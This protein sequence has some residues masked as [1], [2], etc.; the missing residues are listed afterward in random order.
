MFAE[1]R[2]E[3]DAAE[4]VGEREMKLH[5]ERTMLTLLTFLEGKP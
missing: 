5:E 3:E 1:V 2:L 4:E